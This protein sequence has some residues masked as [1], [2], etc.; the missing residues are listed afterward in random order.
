MIFY[1]NGNELEKLQGLEYGA[2]SMCLQRIAN[3]SIFASFW[4]DFQ[5][6]VSFLNMLVTADEKWSL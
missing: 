4:L 3:A 6:H 2:R 1:V 5:L